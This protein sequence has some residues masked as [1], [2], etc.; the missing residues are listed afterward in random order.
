[1]AAMQ[2]GEMLESPFELA[3]GQFEL[4][5][6]RLADDLT[7]GSDA[8]RFVGPGVD[9]AQTRPYS[10]GDSVRSIDWKVTART[11]RYH[12]KEYE[13]P[14]RVP[15]YIV[16]DTSASMAVGSGLLSKHALAVWIGG[17]L[18]LAAYRKRSPVALVSGGVREASF[19][20]TLVR[21]KIW[22]EIASLR[23]PGYA[24]QTRVGARIERIERLA[25]RTSL[26]ILVSDLHEPGVV[27]AVG[28]FRQRHDCIVVQMVDPAEAGALHAGFVRGAEAETGREFFLRSRTRVADAASIGQGLTEAGV[29]HVIIRTDEAVTPVLR[30]A[31][32]SR[33]AGR[34][35]R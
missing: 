5:V 32:D 1:M 11:G 12:V 29:D 27:D 16:V 28:R 21:S 30:R 8:S 18:A 15:V 33:S 17:A 14:K 3:A 2:S 20:P 31:L 9:Y 35:A 34:V 13:A 6:R 10:L 23:E 4:V 25:D 22:G 24:E 7:Y 19:A 26:L